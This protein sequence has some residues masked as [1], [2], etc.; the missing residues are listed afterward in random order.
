MLMATRMAPALA[1]G[2][3]AVPA[4]ASEPAERAFQAAG[5]WTVYIR[6]AIDVALD[7][8][9][10][11][12]HSG[13]GLVV[14]A[15]RGWVLTNAHVASHSYS[16]L[17]ISFR[18]GR[19][20]PAERVYVD[21]YLDVAVIAYDPQAI[22]GRPPEPVLDCESVPPV[23]H[24]VGAFGHPWGLRFT[25]TRG[26]ASAI[27]S[28]LGPDMLQT[29]APIN[30]GNSGGPLISLDTGRIVGLSTAKIS[31][32]SVEGLSFAV[33]MPNVCRILDL[34]R[35]G[36]DPSPP[37]LQ[38]EFA[39]DEGGDRTLTVVHV[40]QPSGSL[41]LEP[42]DHI[43]A[44]GDPAQPVATHG[45]LMNALR[46][47]LDHVVLHVERD[48]S[49][50]VLRGSLPPV[51]LLTQ[52]R[53]FGIAGAYFAES[54]RSR[55]APLIGVG[56]LMVHH[57]QPAS[58]ADQLAVRSYDVLVTANG[59]PVNSVDDLAAVAWRAEREQRE[60]ELVLARLFDRNIDELI[61]YHRRVLTPSELR[62]IGPWR[63][64]P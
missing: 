25:G 36:E 12:T 14:D 26:I 38:V 6:A 44:L 8:D 31:D 13:S 50:V 32:E 57:V 43:V 64:S 56:R 30:A 9:E 4:A 35:A 39:Y 7:D 42:G 49:N 52:R 20:L 54:N 21:P 22:D 2:L 17:A 45:E 55:L 29:D 15:D 58:A 48:G 51:P 28:R 33:P 37:D 60:L 1:L 41:R 18:R 62:P 24:P 61:T 34:L 40:R 23:G 47:T 27:T 10:Q 16:T 53:A 59:Q 11:G 3:L 63:P 19:P 5:N 46:G